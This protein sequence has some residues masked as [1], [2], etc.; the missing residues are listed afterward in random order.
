MARTRA[1]S[2]GEGSEQV[3]WTG[4]RI[5]FHLIFLFFTLKAVFR[6]LGVFFTDSTNLKTQIQ[7]QIL[8]QNM[9]FITFP[10]Y[11]LSSINKDCGGTYQF[12]ALVVIQPISSKLYD[13]SYEILIHFQSK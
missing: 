5:S 4:V 2:R 1:G 3:A 9:H 6:D 11:S 7:L 12:C 13:V 10:R 8:T